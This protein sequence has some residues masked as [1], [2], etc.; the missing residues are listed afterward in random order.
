MTVSAMTASQRGEKHV[1]SDCAC[2]YYDLGKKGAA[3]PKCGGSPLVQQLPRSGRPVKKSPRK[4][5][6]QYPNPTHPAAAAERPA[7]NDAELPE[8][9][10]EL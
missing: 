10:P 3:C 1:C 8:R 5:F 7:S 2:K 4:V 6:G 9:E